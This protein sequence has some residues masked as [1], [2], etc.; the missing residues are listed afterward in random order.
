[1]ATLGFGLLACGCITLQ[2]WLLHAKVA[3]PG[4][5]QCFYQALAASPGVVLGER[6]SRTFGPALLRTAVYREESTALTLDGRP[7]TLTVR[8]KNGA[9][10]TASLPGFGLGR[11]PPLEDS[12]AFLE[13]TRDLERRLAMECVSPVVLKVTERGKCRAPSP[14]PAAP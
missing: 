9:P 8:Y 14:T 11:C 10:R 1:M 4:Q 7:L 13:L 5:S 2:G 6:T 12:E 3:D